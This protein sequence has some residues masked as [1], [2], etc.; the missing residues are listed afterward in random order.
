MSYVCVICDYTAERINDLTRHKNTKK[1]LDMKK[2]NKL[3]CENCGKKFKHVSSLSRHKKS[4][5]VV[6][7]KINND[8]LEIKKI[9]E[10]KDA[11]IQKLCDD[12]QK[13]CD[14]K[15][16]LC[17]DK[18]ALI[19]KAQEKTEKQLEYVH[20][21]LAN[22]NNF[23]QQSFSYIVKRIVPPE[24]SIE[25]PIDCTTICELDDD[26]KTY[27]IL[28]YHYEKNTLVNYFIDLLVDFY[29]KEDPRDQPVLNTDK[30]RVSYVV[31]MNDNDKDDDD[32]IK[33]KWV[34]DKDGIIFSEYG[35]DKMFAHL[36]EY[37]K[38]IIESNCEE[39]KKNAEKGKK[40]DNLFKKFTIASQIR[41]L[42][43]TKT[44]K[45]EII[46]KAGA[47]FSFDKDKYEKK[48]LQLEKKEIN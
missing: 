47:H 6:N 20:A 36:Q 18:I 31:A 5:C 38:R 1:H 8:N 27:E 16:K 44:F 11:M 17:D 26:E 10:D 48:I 43:D 19:T 40:S 15:K 32:D 23:I 37:L 22:S 14:D 42:M 46:K 39:I 7:K 21:Q 29:V 24:L 35:L 13:L 41:S 28:A 3:V 45:Y 25:E 34:K 33:T 12:N 30:S 4:T 2:E 9:I